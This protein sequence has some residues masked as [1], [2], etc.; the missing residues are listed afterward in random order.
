MKVIFQLE[1]Y[2]FFVFLKRHCSQQVI[3]SCDQNLNLDQIICKNYKELSKKHISYI[4]CL[5]MLYFNNF[6]CHYNYD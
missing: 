3:V 4:P 2:V 1:E 6:T 5:L